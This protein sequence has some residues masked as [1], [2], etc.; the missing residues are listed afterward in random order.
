L[1]ADSSSRIG[2]AD[3][4]D[5][6]RKKPSSS[7]VSTASNSVSSTSTLEVTLAR[8]CSAPTDDCIAAISHRDSAALHSSEIVEKDRDRRGAVR[9]KTD[10]LERYIQNLTQQLEMVSSRY[11]DVKALLGG[12]VEAERTLREALDAD[13]LTF[14]ERHTPNLQ[15]HS[16]LQ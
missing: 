10:T 1:A 4:G 14:V 6:G 3:R 5:L 15:G 16:M 11:D 7:P 8:P 2:V 9:R 12:Q 13:I